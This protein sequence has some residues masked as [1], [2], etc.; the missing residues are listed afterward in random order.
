MFYF[1]FLQ[2]GFDLKDKVLN[3][4]AKILRLLHIEELRNLQTNI[5]ECIVSAQSQ[6]ANP[7]T[8]TELGQVGR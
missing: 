4:V 3:D 5:N 7:K 8:D 2:L 6:T 1:L